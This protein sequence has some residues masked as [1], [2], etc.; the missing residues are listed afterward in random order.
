MNYFLYHCLAT[1]LYLQNGKSVLKFI[2][3]VSNMY[4]YLYHFQTSMIS[5]VRHRTIQLHVF[6]HTITKYTDE[7]DDDEMEVIKSV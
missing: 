5:E 4:V 6:L 2:Y 7:Y 3:T 1:S